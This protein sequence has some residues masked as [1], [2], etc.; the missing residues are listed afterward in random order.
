MIVKE[1]NSRIGLTFLCKYCV[2]YYLYIHTYTYTHTHTHTH[3]F[4]VKL[5]ERKVYMGGRRRILVE[6]SAD[7]FIESA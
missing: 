5:A 2:C 6:I 7:G 1:K 3:N 4:K